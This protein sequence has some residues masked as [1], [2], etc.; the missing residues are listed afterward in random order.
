MSTPTPHPYKKL[1]VVTLWLATWIFVGTDVG[2]K[3]LWPS[4]LGLASVLLLQRVIAGLLIGGSAGAILL[5][6]GNPFEAFIAI[7]TDHLIPALQSSWNISV[8]LFTLMLG[9]FVALI[10][11]GGGIQA[12]L[13]RWIRKSG[14]LKKR[15]QWSGFGLG[16]I[17]FF[18]GLANSLLV[19]KT[20]TPL[21]RQAGVSKQ[22]LSYIVDSTSASV[23][24]VAVIS[25]W[26]A[27]QLSMIREGFTLAGVEEVNAFGLFFRSI[28]LNFYCWFTLAL[29]A[30]VIAHNW[31]IG[32]MR[33]AEMVGNRTTPESRPDETDSSTDGAWRAIIPLFVLIAGL[34]VGLYIDGVEGDSLSISFAKVANAFGA[35]DAA[36]VLVTVSAFACLMAFAT[37][38]S[39]IKDEGAPEIFMSGVLNLFTPCLILISVWILTSTLSGLEAAPVLTALIKGNLPSALFPA[40]VFVTGTLISFTTGTSWGTMGVLMP[41]AIPVALSLSGAEGSADAA[42]IP[43]TI[44]AVFSGAVFGDHCSPLSDTTIV[45][46]IACDLDPLEHVQ[47]QIPYALLAASLAMGVGFLPAGLGVPAWISLL[48]GLVILIILPRVFRNPPQPNT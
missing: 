16:I 40:T 37:N 36:K 46:S 11:K 7:F 44:A 13:N 6:N 31:N 1:L 35:A 5:N 12:L 17:C 22:K 15:I 39:K 18:D 9:G 47:T 38:F 41:L 42:L 19:G 29:L 20:L 33:K 26:I 4:I 10:E 8:L 45:S 32:P 27:Y 25:T 30:V 34:M 28:P 43:V 2:I 14:S 3:A 23:A 21:A 24:C 48:V